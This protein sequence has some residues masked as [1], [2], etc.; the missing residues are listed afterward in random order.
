L[1][2]KLLQ[3]LPGVS[4]SDRENAAMQIASAYPP[5]IRE[6]CICEAQAVIA[7]PEFAFL[8]A[9]GSLAEVPVA[10]CVDIDGKKIAVSGQID[11]LHIGD[12]DVWIADFK[13]NRVPGSQI[14][15]RYLR[16]MQLYRLLLK[17]I[18]PEKTIHCA[19]LWTALPR[20]DKL[21]NAL[22]DE[23]RPSSYI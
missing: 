14:P 7:H 5:D 3:Y 21:D 15:S 18:Y 10:G 2:H 4:A 11:R 19:L 16:Q 17:A 8:F 13:S 23:A 22:L 6:E 20:I 9:E 1:I 12:K